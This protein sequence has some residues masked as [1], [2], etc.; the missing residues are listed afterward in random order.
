MRSNEQMSLRS[1]IDKLDHL[2]ALLGVSVL[3]PRKDIERLCASGLTEDEAVRV[4]RRV[5]RGRGWTIENFQD[6]EDEI[7]NTL[8]KR[9]KSGAKRKG[10]AQHRNEC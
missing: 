7:A 5:I 6:I 8:A 10:T 2:V 4:W 3:P 1:N 9:G